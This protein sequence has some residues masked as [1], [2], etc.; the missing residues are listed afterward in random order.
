VGVLTGRSERFRI[1]R[2][3]RWVTGFGALIAAAA[4][5]WIPTGARVLVT[6]MLILVLTAIDTVVEWL[7]RRRRSRTQLG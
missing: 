6:A 1:D 5:G 3:V 4:L 2:I 7:R